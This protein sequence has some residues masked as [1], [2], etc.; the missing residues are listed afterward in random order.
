MVRLSPRIVISGFLLIL[1]A[2]LIW[3]SPRL[4]EVFLKAVQF[5]KENAV[6]NQLVAVAFFTAL[7]TFSAMFFLLSSTPLVPFAIAA[8]GSSLTLGLLLLG[9]I[10][11]GILT[12]GAGRAASPLVKKLAVYERITYYREKLTTRSQFWFV[13]LFR[14]AIPA[15]IPGYVLG[16]LRYSFGKY[17]LATSISEFLVAVI[18]VYASEALLER[19]EIFFIF[20]VIV[21]VLLF[22]FLHHIFH[23][24]LPKKS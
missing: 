19:N 20:L 2:V 22:S 14:L 17:L 9:W 1:A 5:L 4:G 15:E 16:S 23:K 6:E 3:Y 12:Y 21:S 10:L 7:S 18:A 11:G 24:R 8:W 13:L